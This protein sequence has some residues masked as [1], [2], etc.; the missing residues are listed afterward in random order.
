M[1]KMTTVTKERLQITLKAL[2]V[3]SE[4]LG[5]DVKRLTVQQLVFLLMAASNGIS[6]QQK[7]FFTLNSF[8]AER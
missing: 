4:E 5:D 7:L 8:M 1:K 6:S 2:Q 3:F